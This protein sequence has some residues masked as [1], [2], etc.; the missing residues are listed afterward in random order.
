MMFE[1]MESK[2][3]G[4]TRGN[5]RPPDHRVERDRSW[6]TSFLLSGLREKFGWSRHGQPIL[7][8]LFDAS[9]QTLLEKGPQLGLEEI[10]T[11]FTFSR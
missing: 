10:P 7:K 4:I 6:Q 1:F 5:F 8:E 11:Q 9:Y 3:F 2:A